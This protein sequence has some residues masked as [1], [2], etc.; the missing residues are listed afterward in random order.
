MHGKQKSI[1]VMS[2]QFKLA[3]TRRSL[4][5]R[6]HVRHHIVENRKE[7]IVAKKLCF[8]GQESLEISYSFSPQKHPFATVLDFLLSRVEMLFASFSTFV[9]K[10]TG[11][12]HSIQQKSESHTSNN[13]FIC[14]PDGFTV[15]DSVCD[16]WILHSICCCR[17]G[18]K[19]FIGNTIKLVAS[20]QL[21]TVSRMILTT[22][23]LIGSVFFMATPSRRLL[24]L[25]HVFT[26]SILCIHVLCVVLSCCLLTTSNAAERSLLVR[27]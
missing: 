16:Y 22:R 27:Q 24:L 2:Y 12:S 20:S 17:H 10:V 21:A 15:N 1:E 5:A 4:L 7:V 23:L 25:D 11:D 14:F 18:P 6:Y 19:I 26:L 8:G 3:W 9:T 13:C